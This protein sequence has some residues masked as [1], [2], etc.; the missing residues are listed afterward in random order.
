MAEVLFGICTL[1]KGI[2]RGVIF[3]PFRDEI[4]AFFATQSTNTSSFHSN[5]LSQAI[6]F[7]LDSKYQ[8][9]EIYSGNVALRDSLEKIPCSQCNVDHTTSD[10][11]KTV[12]II[13]ISGID[14]LSGR[15]NCAQKLRLSWGVFEPRRMHPLCSPFGHYLW[16]SRRDT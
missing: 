14:L 1:G 2:S 3:I 4:V 8:H 10:L 13:T 6:N 15:K 5:K 16:V 7:S 9:C 11:Q 12:T